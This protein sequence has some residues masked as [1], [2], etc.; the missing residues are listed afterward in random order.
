MPDSPLKK[1]LLIILLAAAG[2][3]LLLQFINFELKPQENSPPKNFKPDFVYHYAPPKSAGSR[4]PAPT[5][6]DEA[7]SAP[8]PKIS[9]EQAEAWLAKHNRNAMSLLAA[10]RAMGDTNYLNEAATNF[11]NDPHVE[12]AVLSRDEF[13][14]DRRKWLD[15]FKQS[16]PSNSLAN[17]FSAEDD[18][19]NGK[20]DEAVQELLAASGKEQFQNYTM[21]TLLDSEEL[22]SASGKSPMEVTTDSMADMAG[23]NL[24]QLA[25]Y[26][27]LAQ[28]IGNLEQQYAASG[29]ANSTVNLAQMGMTLANQIQ[30][31]DSGKY[32]INQLVGIADEKIVLSKLDPN[33]SY[34]FLDGQTPT[35]VMQ[36]LKNQRKSYNELVTPFLAAYPNMTPDEMVNY[37]ERMK[38]YGETAAM[39]WVIEQHPPA[40]AA[41]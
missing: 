34:D 31:G 37:S 21:E 36:Q 25:T 23:E 13:P 27:R 35:Q 2:A 32:L 41:K 18:F 17:Y 1:L 28:G 15:L 30:S 8:A 40:D 29:D 26:K 22:Y 12:L 24:P 10:F 16:S 6:S 39:Q 38:I 4:N 14:A 19:K 20:S 9:R 7:E 33:T 3:A 11:P 5:N